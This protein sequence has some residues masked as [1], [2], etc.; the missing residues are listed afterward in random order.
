[1]AVNICICYFSS[2][3]IP[4][5]NLF[6]SDYNMKAKSLY[7]IFAVLGCI[8]L[9]LW[10]YKYLNVDLWY[11]EAYS[12]EHFALVDWKLTVLN[13]P[14]PNNH[15]FFNLTSQLLS[16]IT[17]LRDLFDATENIYV[18]RLFQGIIALVTACYSATILKRHLKV[19]SSFLV[20]VVLFTSI[21][22]MNFALQLRG[23]NMSALFLVMLI[24]YTW[25]YL[26]EGGR[27]AQIMMVVTS[28]LLLYTIPSN[29]Y[30]LLG[31]WLVL[32]GFWVYQFKKK[33]RLQTKRNFRTL[34][35][36]AAGV[37]IAFLCY[38]PIIE[39]VIFNKFSMRTVPGI[40]Y[41]A[42]LFLDLVP[43]FVSE[44]HFL[45]LLLL[46]GVYF[47]YK[48]ASGIEKRNFIFL[49]CLFLVPFG[50]SFLHQKAP[51]PRV[52]IPLAP[53][54]AMLITVLAAKFIDEIK[55]QYQ[56]YILLL[57]T[58]A[59]SILLF[60]TE[61]N[62][63]ATEVSKALIEENVLAQ[64]LY[65]NYYLGDFFQQDK[66]A[67]EFSE[68]YTDIPII[69]M[70]DLDKPSTEL[71]LRKNEVQFHKA[72]SVEHLLLWSDLFTPFYIVTSEKDKTLEALK[73][74]TDYTTEVISDQGY[75]STLIRVDD[76]QT[77]LIHD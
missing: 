1:M 15:I 20:Y 31:F 9:F 36:I 73:T 33:E 27:R 71:Y 52:F 62:K 47:F 61:M 44:R 46:P 42:G 39:E 28:V 25:N 51:F 55:Q 13:Y 23:Y 41:S 60:T 16:R 57:G 72:E 65:Q 35:L 30:F 58:I 18:F 56:H 4:R 7:Y 10:G 74:K 6:L 5:K 22:F 24:Y 70:F 3:L 69:V 14:A 21:P 12:L 34:V 53:V 19:K 50:I 11:D 49:I 66:V 48:N 68:K 54:F 64:N 75:F 29:V 37:V 32:L 76:Q 45:L 17:G 63:N 40:F 59:Y 43:D 77:N 38:L 67:K 2:A 8:P 26:S